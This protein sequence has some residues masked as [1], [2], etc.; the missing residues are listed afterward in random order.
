MDDQAQTIADI[1]DYKLLMIAT[2]ALVPLLAVSKKSTAQSDDHARPD[3]DGKLEIAERGRAEGD[4]NPDGHLLETLSRS[5]L[6]RRRR[7]LQSGP[8]YWIEHQMALS[9][10]CSTSGPCQSRRSMPRRSAVARRM[11]KVEV[12]GLRAHAGVDPDGCRLGRRR[13]RSAWAPSLRSP[14]RKPVGQRCLG[15]P[16]PDSCQVTGPL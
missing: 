5:C 3:N 12:D 2:L 7:A 14:P 10:H 16:M 15:F 13:L 1:E 9:K 6:N 4:E 8:Q 11:R